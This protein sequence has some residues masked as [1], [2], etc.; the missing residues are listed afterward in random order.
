MKDE[1]EHK[2]L[3]LKELKQSKQGL[4]PLDAR[5]RKLAQ[6]EIDIYN[7]SEQCLS[8]ATV[9]QNFAIAR[10]ELRTL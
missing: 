5:Q 2:K 9:L 10:P 4:V 7:T 3:E 6:T 8:K 1:V